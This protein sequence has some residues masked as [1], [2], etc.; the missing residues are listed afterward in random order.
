[1][2]YFTI[3]E[4]TTTNTGK[5]NNPRPSAYA[6]LLSLVDNLLDP[7][8]LAWGS[9]ILVNSGYRSFAVNKAVGGVANS[10]HMK[11]QAVDITA[12]SLRSNLELFSLLKNRFQFD[13]LILEQKG[14][15]IHVSWVDGKNRNEVLYR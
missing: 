2:K 11:G 7:L 15:W 5:P 13:Q 3:A 8:R 1:M 9:P 6:N 4:L 14:K 10:Q 12:G